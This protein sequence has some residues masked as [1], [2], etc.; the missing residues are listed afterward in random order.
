[1]K[2]P[3]P[4]LFPLLR[5]I[6]VPR[7][8]R[9]M[10][11]VRAGHKLGRIGLHSARRILS[12]GML[13][14]LAPLAAHLAAQTFP[15]IHKKA[16]WPDGRGELRITDDAIEFQAAGKEQNSRKWSYADIQYLDRV[17]TKELV[18]L[19]YEDHK[20][21]LGRDREFRF[22]LTEGEI[23]DALF[24][25]LQARLKKP[26]TDRVVPD[27][28]ASLYETPVK[29]LH[30][31]GGCEGRLLFTANTAVYKTP[32][33]Q[34]ARAWRLDTDVESVWSD[35][36]YHLE[37]HVYENNRREF[38]RTRVYS[39]VLKQPLDGE[40]Y[41]SLKMKLYGLAQARELLR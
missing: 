23:S 36:P 6:A 41:R 21:E 4:A 30:P 11:P 3:K 37:I 9:A 34:D 25:T 29:H 13:V 40:F 39:F 14:L 19:T 24:A 20:W 22:L 18:I 1:M 38:S 15:V 10:G 7:D 26:V 5:W 32:H 31:F 12:L 16:L 28:V 8:R 33:E 17:S 2:N 27:V 35:D